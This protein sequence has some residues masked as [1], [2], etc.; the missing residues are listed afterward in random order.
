MVALQLRIFPARLTWPQSAKDAGAIARDTT[1]LRLVNKAIGFESL[2]EFESLEALW[3]FGIDQTKLEQISACTSLKELYCEYH[4]R[5]SDLRCLSRLPDLEVLRLDSCPSIESLA[6][7]GDFTDLNGLGIENFKNVHD[8]EPLAKLT[9]LRQLAVEGSIWT[10]MKIDSLAPLSSLE[11]LEFLGLTSLKVVDESLA[12]LANLKNLRQLFLTNAYPFEEFA[13]LAA[14]LP[15]TECQWFAP[16]V[17][18]TLKCEECDEEDRVLLT[19]KGKSLLC[20]RCDAKRLQRHV[21]A[22]DRVKNDS[23]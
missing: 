20:P 16:Y 17:S 21:A 7:L 9:N 14:Q 10:R 13:R 15:N 4:L 22:F 11:R 3:C 5:I 1:R 12:P 19:G 2:R 23:R 8:V 18:T 6:Q